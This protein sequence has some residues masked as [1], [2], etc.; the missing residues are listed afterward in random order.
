MEGKLRDATIDDPGL[1]RCWDEQNLATADLT[2]ADRTGANL[3]EAGLR[4]ANLT[5]AKIQNAKLE[6]AKFCKTP[7]PDGK[8]NTANC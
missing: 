4:G 6:A 7:M 1:L 5:G 2:Q 3:R 8:S